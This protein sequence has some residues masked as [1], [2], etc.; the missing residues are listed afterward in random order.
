MRRVVLATAVAAALLLTAGGAAA[1]GTVGSGT[2]G[3]ERIQRGVVDIGIE[4]MLLVHYI[5]PAVAGDGES[6]SLYA[7]YAGGLAFRYFLMNNLAVGITG[8]VLYQ[9]NE[10]TATALDADGNPSGSTT[11]ESSDLG[12]IG[13]VMLNYYL[14]L[15]NSLFFKPGVGGGAL[16]ATRSVPDP[17]NPGISIES[18]L[19]GGTARLDL[20]FAYYASPNFTLRAGPD[21]VLRLGVQ[22]FDDGRQSESFTSVDAGFNVGLGYSF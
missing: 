17:S 8:A 6:T 22:E 7:T 1:Q 21:I 4:N 9:R 3:Y 13:F 14:R 12:F 16:Y 15:G 10:D 11:R 2:R 20:G 5:A 18:T 19:I